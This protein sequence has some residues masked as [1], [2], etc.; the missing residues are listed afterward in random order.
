MK[1]LLFTLAGLLLGS[2]AVFAQAGIRLNEVHLNPPN[3][4]GNYEFIELKS[5]SNGVESCAGLTLVIINNDR[6]D[7]DTGAAQDIGV[8]KEAWSLDELSTGTNGLLLLGNGYTGSPRGG[9]WAGFIDPATEVGDPSGMGDS[10]IKSNDGLSILLVSGFTGAKDQD[11]DAD[12]NGV[13]D[14]TPW[15]AVIDSIGTKDRDTKAPAP[16]GTN[17]YVVSAAN[18]FTTWISSSLADRDPDTFARQLNNNTPSNAASWYGG[19]LQGT[20]SNTVTYVTNRF[21]GPLAGNPLKALL[22]EVTP[23]RP[24]LAEGLPDTDFRI[25]EVNLNPVGGSENDIYQY[26]EIINTNLSAR[27][28]QNYWLV[29]LDSYD[30]SSEPNGD[31]SPGGGKILEKWDLSGMATGTNGLLLLGDSFSS[32]VNPFRDLVSPQTSLGS[33]TS[34]GEPVS[35]DTTPAATGF[36]VGDIRFKD[37]FTLVLV[38]GFVK[39]TNDDFDIGD[40]GVIDP[41]RSLSQ[42]GT[43]VDQVGFSQAGKTGLGKTYS[44]VDL[45]AVMPATLVPDNFSR[46][47]GDMSV[48]TTAWYGGSFTNNT[49]PTNLGYDVEI[50]N[51]SPQWFGGFRGA[52]TPGLPNVSATIDSTNTLAPAQ[53]RINEVMINPSDVSATIKDDNREYIELVSSNNGIA[54]LDGLWILIVSLED[55][56]SG[57]IVGSFPLNGLNTGLNG[58]IIGGDG[59]DNPGGYPYTSTDGPLPSTCNYFD[60]PE[61]LGGDDFPNNGVAILLVRNPISGGVLTPSVSGLRFTG[62]LDPENDGTLLAPSA[63]CA[64]LVDSI[65]T[66]PRNPGSAYA[67]IDSTAFKADHVARLTGNFTANSKAAWQWGQ[68]VQDSP[69]RVATIEYTGAFGGPFR[70]AASP[71]RPN[72]SAPLG[73][74][75]EGGVLLN[76]VNVNPAGADKNFEFVELLS[77]AGDSRSLNG[78]TLVSIDNVGPNTGSIRHAWSLDGM[79]TGANGLILIGNKYPLGGTNNPFSAIMSPQTNTGDPSGRDGLATSF[80]DGV[81]GDD[82]DNLSFNLML[83]RG[84]TGYIGQDLDEKVGASNGVDSPGDGIF[85]RSAWDSIHDSIMFRD[86][87]EITGTA[88]AYAPWDGWTYNLADLSGYYLTTT[89]YHPETFARFRGEN[90]P[91]FAGAWYGGDLTGGATGGSGTSLAYETGANGTNP[92]FPTGFTGS[93]T[94]GLPNLSRSDDPD[95]DGVGALLE[96]AFGTNPNV[97]ESPYPYPVVGTTTVGGVTYASISYRRLKGGTTSASDVYSGGG[98]SYTVETSTDLKSWVNNGSTVDAAGAAVANPDGTTETATFRLVAP[99]TAPAGR[100]YMRLRVTKP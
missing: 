12:N 92:P 35:P 52:A 46:K 61:G 41:G 18:I 28:L 95:G 33:P 87:P 86:Q 44:T 20:T 30:G 16:S 76:E 65:T 67:W 80:S 36:S 11:L 14:S 69:G 47:P 2:K 66:G 4:D 93:V 75:A 45:R 50:A 77:A 10:D 26:I 24:N 9:P 5:V 29:L 21:F 71:G 70:G 17:P 37:G 25:N 82:N 34:R 72:H 59:Y 38:K 68:I 96:G 31:D 99:V 81:L 97:A 15:T 40:D 63:Y 74:I 39:P 90:T 83:V 89:Y 79:S 1:K 94:P 54:Y 56:A 23:G 48:S 64:E 43:V 85:D 91:N 100:A 57:T 6:Y 32:S 88:P 51:G 49:A 3:P 98:Y 19:K 84:Y 53:I 78:Y 73:S 42:L 8:I 55:N 13:L 60:P 62:D 22:G 7:N 58:I 27:S